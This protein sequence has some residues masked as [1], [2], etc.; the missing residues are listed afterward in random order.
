MDV[1]MITQKK[2][3]QD[4][5]RRLKKMF[6]A[7]SLQTNRSMSLSEKKSPAARPTLSGA[8]QVDRAATLIVLIA[9]LTFA[10]R[11]F[12]KKAS[13][14]CRAQASAGDIDSSG[15]DAPAVPAEQGTDTG[16][17]ACTHGTFNAHDKS[18]FIYH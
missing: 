15:R 9:A 1:S 6:G 16:A 2:T 4:E 5:N 12:H 11:K 10:A 14:L 17:F 8:G 7:Q 18:E 3:V 13:A